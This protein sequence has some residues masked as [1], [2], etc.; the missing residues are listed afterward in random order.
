MLVP[1][2]ARRP[3]GGLSVINLDHSNA[4][5]YQS[6]RHQAL[7]S[8]VI[9][10]RLI[11]SIQFSSRFSFIRDVK[12]FRSLALH[13]ERQLKGFKPSVESTVVGP[14]GCMR[15]IQVSQP[16]ELLTLSRCIESRVA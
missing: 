10:H 12:G 11:D 9:R 14:L 6:S 5:L 13:A 1:Q 7:L 2:L 8:K 3:L 15:Y 16:I 4:S